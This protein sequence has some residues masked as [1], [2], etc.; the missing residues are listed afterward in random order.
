MDADSSIVV[1][2]N[3][4][5]GILCDVKSYEEYEC[6]YASLFVDLCCWIVTLLLHVVYRCPVFSVH[7]SFAMLFG[8]YHHM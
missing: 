8:Y 1:I 2:L 4:A 7:A 5:K 6:V 3:V